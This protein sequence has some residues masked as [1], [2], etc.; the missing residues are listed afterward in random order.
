MSFRLLNFLLSTTNPINVDCVADHWANICRIMHTNRERCADV[1]KCCGTYYCSFVLMLIMVFLDHAYKQRK[2]CRL[3][4]M[5]WYM[6][7]FRF[8]HAHYVFFFSLSYPHCCKTWFYKCMHVVEL[9]ESL[10]VHNKC[11]TNY[12]HW[13]SMPIYSLVSMLIFALLV[14]AQLRL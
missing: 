14:D 6:L 1:V 7:L 5:L 12:L 11:T 8:T 3:C 13:P 9:H 4:Q 2:V 10:F